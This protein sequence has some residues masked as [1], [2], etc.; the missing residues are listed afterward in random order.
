MVCGA[1]PADPPEMECVVFDMGR[2]VAQPIQH[3]DRDHIL[4]V[5]V[6]ANIVYGPCRC[7]PG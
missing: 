6:I 7:V 5:F 4:P 2:Y 1:S 3:V